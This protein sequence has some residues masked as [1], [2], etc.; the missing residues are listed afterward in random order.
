M[1]ARETMKH[2]LTKLGRQSGQ[3][4][5]VRLSLSAV[6]LGAETAIYF[7]LSAV[8]AGAELPEDC[9]PFGVAMVAAAGS[10]L[11]GA[12]ALLGSCFGY[13]CMLGFSQ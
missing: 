7:L 13:L 11:R 2:K 10:G 8:L 3:E 5:Q 12:G 6:S 1:T 9:A 4:R